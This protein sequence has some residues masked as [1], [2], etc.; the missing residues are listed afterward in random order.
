MPEYPIP[1]SEITNRINALVDTTRM[2]KLT[3]ATITA[4]LVAEELLYVAAR[5][6]GKT[7]KYPTENG[8][9]FGISTEQRM[10][11]GGEYTVLLYNSYA[12]MYILKNMPEIIG[13][14]NEKRLPNPLPQP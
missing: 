6:D 12:Q 14:Y 10:G 1:I 9:R 13:M 4:W 2:R 11:A 7:S 3:P 5:P 8:Q